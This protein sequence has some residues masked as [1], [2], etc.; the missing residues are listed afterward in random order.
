MDQRTII[1]VIGSIGAGK[2]Y[3][4][5]T[6][7]KKGDICLNWHMYATDL[8]NEVPQNAYGSAWEEMREEIQN[9]TAK[10]IFIETRPYTDL[11]ECVLPGY[12]VIV[13]DVH[14]YAGEPI[15]GYPFKT[16]YAD[17]S[18]SNRV[19]FTPPIYPFL[20]DH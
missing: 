17:N 6:L 5:G 13:V 2:S 19:R 1:F 20:F 14:R 10:I 15:G 11:S 9:S 7:A 12:R 4:I 8:N 3:V 18:Q 16:I